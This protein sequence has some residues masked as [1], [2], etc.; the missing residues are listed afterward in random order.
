[1][2]EILKINCDDN[3]DPA[4]IGSISSITTTNATFDGQD[5]QLGN[6][7]GE[8]ILI[9][10]AY[11]DVDH[12]DFQAKFGFNSAWAVTPAAHHFLLG[13]YDGDLGVAGDRYLSQY[14]GTYFGGSPAI[15]YTEY[16]ESGGFFQVIWKTASLSAIF[17]DTALSTLRLVV[18]CNTPVTGS[19]H[20]ALYLDGV[21]QPISSGDVTTS[22][23]RWE[24]SSDDFGVLGNGTPGTGTDFPTDAH[25]DDIS[26]NTTDG[27]TC[28]LTVDLDPAVSTGWSR[29]GTAPWNLSGAATTIPKGVSTITYRPLAGHEAPATEGIEIF[30]DTTIS[31]NYISTSNISISDWLDGN[32]VAVSRHNEQRDENGQ[33]SITCPAV[34]YPEGES[35][36]QA[37]IMRGA[38]VVIDWHTVLTTP[39]GTSSPFTV[40]NIPEGPIN[41]ATD[42]YTVEV[43][44]LSDPSDTAVSA[45]DF[46]VGALFGLIGQS[47]GKEWTN[48]DPETYS[49]TADPYNLVTDNSLSFLFRRIDNAYNYGSNHDPA[50]IYGCSQ[51][52]GWNQLIRGNG[53]QGFCNKLIEALDIPI[54]IVDGCINGVNVTH[55]NTLTSTAGLQFYPSV[56]EIGGRLEGIVIVNGEDEAM[57]GDIAEYTTRMNT[58]FTTIRANIKAPDGVSPVPI[59][60]SLLGRATGT[61]TWNPDN[62]QAIRDAQNALIANNDDVYFGM[63]NIDLG[64]QPNEAPWEGS[65]IH[66]AFVDQSTVGQ[67]A[68]QAV[69]HYLG[70]AAYS[71]GPTQTWEAISSTQTRFIISP[72][73]GNDFTPL[74]GY[75]GY[76]GFD[77]AVSITISSITKESANS[78]IATH[79]AITGQRTFRYMYGK[80]ATIAGTSNVLSAVRDSSPMTLPLKSNSD[81]EEY[82]AGNPIPVIEWSIL[83]SISQDFNWYLFNQELFVLRFG[84][85]EV[86]IGANVC[87]VDSSKY[88]KSNDDN[89]G[90][91]IKAEMSQYVKV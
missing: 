19:S 17:P 22:W 75:V 4:E 8:L 24:G 61:S 12:L 83:S 49:G 82:V 52:Q 85:S 73:G 1:M 3:T 79:D 14:S 27:W 28:G 46:G 7:V 74:S 25:V 6:A 45:W 26:I 40:N 57:S 53:G 47:N 32:S 18:D 63:S 16:T 50:G 21:L 56:D 78:L 86:Q 65:D 15:V 35:G 48:D 80:D 11:F 68:A 88:Y 29:T 31:R 34:T 59:F 60:L 37:R 87:T 9:P 36:I 2:A 84:I 5:T 90:F 89:V 33:G 10:A 51:I 38:T 81:I 41:G 23:T 76:E 54:G 30:T 58:L 55:F 43:R 72:D 69:L 44:L 67:R 66:T 39:A 20:V 77:D 91:I 64:L 13:K 70:E 62:F 42:F 71:E